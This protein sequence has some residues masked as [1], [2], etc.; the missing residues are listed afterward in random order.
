MGALLITRK[1]SAVAVCCLRDPAR[2]SEDRGHRGRDHD[3]RYPALH[4]RGRGRLSRARTWPSGQA[5]GVERAR[6]ALRGPGASPAP[7]A[8]FS[9]RPRKTRAPA[10]RVY[11]SCW[12]GPPARRQSAAQEDARMTVPGIFVMGIGGRGTLLCSILGDELARTPPL[13]VDSD[14]SLKTAELTARADRYLLEPRRSPNRSISYARKIFE[15]EREALWARIDAHVDR[16]AA[17][18]GGPMLALLASSPRGGISNAFT[19]EIA[20]YLK[21]KL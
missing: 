7:S 4:D 2:R 14:P 20:Q 18:P 8:L 5:P 19:F 12:P 15:D 3:G 13:C 11:S 21:D 10:V 9:G 16:L 17:S 6:P 1:I